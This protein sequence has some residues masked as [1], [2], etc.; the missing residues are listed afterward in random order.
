[1]A[2]LQKRLCANIR[3]RGN[4][5]DNRRPV[6]YAG[7]TGA[8]AASFAIVAI[9][10]ISSVAGRGP[11]PAQSRASDVV[12]DAR[13]LISGPPQMAQRQKKYIERARVGAELS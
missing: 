3:H 10:R 8:I 4:T 12:S 6:R 13:N 2:D 9:F 5:D 1:M 11:T 7:D